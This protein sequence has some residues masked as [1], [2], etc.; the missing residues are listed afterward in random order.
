[1]PSAPAPGL[2]TLGLRQPEDLMRTSVKY[3]DPAKT[4]RLENPRHDALVP[5]RTVLCARN[6]ACEMN[7]RQLRLNKSFP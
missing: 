4:G 2:A 1:M 7:G 5:S 3:R 6:R